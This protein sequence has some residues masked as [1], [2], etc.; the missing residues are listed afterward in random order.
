MKLLILSDLHFEFHADSGKNFVDTLPT[1]GVDVC[2]L[3]GDITTWPGIPHA[4]RCFCEKYPEVIY[5]HGN[6]EFYGGPKEKAYRQTEK[7]CKENSNLHWL[8]CSH[9]EI[10]GQ[11]F[12]GGPLWFKRSNG[13]KWA[14]ADFM[15]IHGLES[16]VYDAN[17]QFINFLSDNLTSKDVVISHHLPSQKSVAPMYKG[18]ALNSYFLCDVEPLI[19]DRL[20][21]LWVHGHTHESLDYKI[22]DTTRVVCN[23]FG[24]V[25]VELNRFFREDFI[26]DV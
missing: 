7:A 26:I 1:E 17:R 14:M 4:L 9:V 6:H 24:Y 19:R 15:H 20:P 2:I 18:N 11:R 21:K 25:G 10:G 13:P 16:W 22:L 3:A 23:P 8:D 5:V 12:L